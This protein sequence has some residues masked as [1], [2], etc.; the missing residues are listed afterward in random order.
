MLLVLHMIRDEHEEKHAIIDF[1]PDH[2][3]KCFT[4]LS[5]NQCIF[6]PIKT[7]ALRSKMFFLFCSTGPLKRFPVSA[8]TDILKDVLTSYLQEEKYEVEW[9]QKMTKTICEVNESEKR[10]HLNAM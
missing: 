9:S 4:F 1:L 5:L 6:L 8:V 2:S 10:V 3:L 7:F